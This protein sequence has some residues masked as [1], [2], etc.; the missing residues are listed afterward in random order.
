MTLSDVYTQTIQRHNCAITMIEWFKYFLCDTS[1][2]GNSKVQRI[3]TII[4]YVLLN[5]CKT[6]T[7]TFE[8][9]YF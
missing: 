4:R 3:H 2:E 8:L 6:P 1:I 7:I 5:K 9:N